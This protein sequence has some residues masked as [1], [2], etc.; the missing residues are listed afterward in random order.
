MEKAALQYLQKTSDSVQKYGL[1]HIRPMHREIAR[2]LVLGQRQ[3]DVAAELG[4]SDSRMSI[5]VN[6]PLFKREIDRLEKLREEGVQ[7]VQ[8]TLVEVSPLALE[9]VERTMY[10][11]KSERLRFDAA[12]S[13]LD[14]AGHSKINKVDIR[15]NINNRVSSMSDS[16]VKRLIAERISRIR[17]K[18]LEEERLMAEA[19]ATEVTFDEVST[20]LRMVTPND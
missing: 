12:E 18:T 14:R 16:E 1:S 8:R 9:V 17:E 19:D 7:D 15:G 2:R 13:I 6:S 10:G 5:I 20:D 11:G 3:G 4:I